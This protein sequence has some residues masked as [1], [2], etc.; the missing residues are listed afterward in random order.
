ML[1]DGL[2]NTNVV[3]YEETEEYRDLVKLVHDWYEAGYIMR[4]IT[5]TQEGYSSLLKA[6]KGYAYLN[7]AKAGYAEQAT[8]NVGAP[9]LHYR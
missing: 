3:L 5:T 6:G 1:N 8:R 4:D 9:I 2:D 7:G